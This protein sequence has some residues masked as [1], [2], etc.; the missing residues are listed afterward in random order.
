[1]TYQLRE[2]QKA[3]V[4]A[5]LAH[6]RKRTT[7]C[8]LDLATGAGKSLVAANIAMEIERL[9]GKK[10]LVLAPSKELVEQN[11]E[12]YTAYGNRASFF[13][14]AVGIKSTRHSAVFG[15]PRTVL[16]SIDQFKHGFAAVVIDEAHQTSNT[17]RQIVGEMRSANPNLRVIGMTATPYRL[18]EG[19]IYQINP[20]GS[21]VPPE[22]LT[23]KAFFAKLVY[24]VSTRELISRGYLTEPEFYSAGVHYAAG[25]MQTNSRGQFDAGEIAEV[26]EG[27]GRLTADI[28]ADAVGRSQPGLGVIFFAASIRH[29][30]EIC[31]SLPQHMTELVTGETPKKDRARILAA[32]KRGDIR[33]LVNV[34]VLTT[35]FDAPNVGT[36]AILRATESPGLLLQIIGR[37]LRLHDGKSKV[38]ILDYAENLERHAP[39]GDVFDPEIRA[40][41]TSGAER[42]PVACPCCG[43]T[44]MFA[45]KPNDDGWEIDADGYFVSTLGERII[46]DAGKPVA[47]HFGQR[48]QNIIETATTSDRCS[49]RWDSRGC[50][51]C[52]GENSLSAR[53]C[54]HCGQELVDPN[55]KLSLEREKQAQK[56]RDKEAWHTD[57]VV[58]WSARKTENATAIDYYLDG[59]K[60]VTEYLCPDH[61]KRWVAVKAKRRCIQLGINWGGDIV[62]Q[63]NHGCLATYPASLTYR[64]Q[65]G[66]NFF[67]VKHK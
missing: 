6:I 51:E 60:V 15:T 24:R 27:K 50:P 1:M 57:N 53:E 62:H 20:D 21:P 5:V 12:K 58:G 23:D 34:A 13:S 67:E 18:G 41:S 43:H 61:A 63:V 16:N 36:V 19:Y 54:I 2:Y 45:L 35:G 39:A 17:M 26:F 42:I 40:K 59:G 38:M 14:A 44:N 33:Y 47:A 66:S 29:A 65:N 9:S 7:S 8:L 55:D 11:F 49:H 4:D 48:C 25:G 30:M 31:E 56:E 3:S 37:G 46:N 22:Q 32:F 10:T 28:V 52:G 64:R